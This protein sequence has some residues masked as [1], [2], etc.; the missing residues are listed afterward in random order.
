MTLAN[1][2]AAA[3]KARGMN[4]NQLATA[5]GLTAGYLH[6]VQERNSNGMKLENVRK[7]AAALSVSASWLAT[8][9]GDGPTPG[10]PEP[11]PHTP[12]ARSEVRER[13]VADHWFP[14][15]VEALY[16]KAIKLR[17]DVDYSPQVGRVAKVFVRDV[18][19]QLREGLTRLDL[20]RAALEAAREIEAGG[21]EPT[22]DAIHGAF[23]SAALAC[24]PTRTGESNLARRLREA[25]EQN[26]REGIVPEM[27]QERPPLPVVPGA[28]RV[29]LPPVPPPASGP[30][31]KGRG[32]R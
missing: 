28:R 12:P 13:V 22:V 7:I 29:E 4:Q 16:A 8:G 3:M 11:T 18:T 31:R 25:D 19:Y 30:V 2:I 17:A 26:R 9:E 23:L 15:E 24:A 6:K 1:R 10:A 5:T 27:A 32:G 14:D 21:A 20:M